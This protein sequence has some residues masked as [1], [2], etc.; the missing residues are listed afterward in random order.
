[1][2]MKTIPGRIAMS[3]LACS[4]ELTA[5]QARHLCNQRTAV[6]Q[7]SNDFCPITLCDDAHSD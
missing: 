4:L 6:P 5:L 7:R 2:L 1:M 3:L